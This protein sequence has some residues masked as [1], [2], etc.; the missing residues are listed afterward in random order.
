MAK[1]ESFKLRVIGTPDYELEGVEVE[2][3]QWRSETEI[4][5]LDAIDIGLITLP[6]VKL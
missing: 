3:L 1:E 6:D 5:D 2:V 4:E